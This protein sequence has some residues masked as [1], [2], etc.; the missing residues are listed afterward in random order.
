LYDQ[1]P[2]ADLAA[3]EHIP[4]VSTDRVPADGHKQFVSSDQCKAC[5]SGDSSS[6]GPNLIVQGVDVSP[7]A[8]WRWRMMGLAGRDPIFYAQLETE[9]ASHGRP[10]TEFSDEAI[11]NFC[12]RC[13][14]VM[15]QRQFTLDNPDELFTARAAFAHTEDDPLRTYGGLARDGVSC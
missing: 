6:F 10:G 7:F 15:G 13:H 2:L 1:F 4:P 3:I 11:E 8:E 5:H 9:T 12:L 14:G